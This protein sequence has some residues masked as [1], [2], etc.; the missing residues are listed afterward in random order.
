M[1]RNQDTLR[2]FYGALKGMDEHLRFVFLTGVTRFAHLSL[3][4]GLNNLNDIS[5]DAQY[6]ALC[7]I[8][9]GELRADLAGGVARLA[10]RRGQTVEEAYGKLKAMYDGYR[11]SPDVP[12]GSTTPSAC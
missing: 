9:E 5:L 11:F 8:T 3:F 10:A 2:G 4:S 7:G 12:G 6:A 1:A